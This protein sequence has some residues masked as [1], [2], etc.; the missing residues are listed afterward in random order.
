[1]YYPKSRIIEGLYTNGG[2]FKYKINN[3][4]Y[5]GYYHKFYNG[6][7]FSG[8]TQ[9]SLPKQEII[10]IIGN[11]NSDVDKLYILNTD[12]K[13]ALFLND[14]DPIVDISK[15][16]QSEIIKYLKL[17]GLPT[18]E[19][20]PRNVPQIYY[21]NPTDKD[22]EN[23][24]IKRYFAMKINER[25]VFVEI[26]KDI[27]KKLK[28]QDKKWMWERYQIFTLVWTIVGETKSQ[29]EETNRNIL[30][31][32]QR[33]IRRNGLIAYLRGN[34][35]KFFK[36]LSQLKLE[37]APPQSKKINKTPPNANPIPPSPSE[38]R[39]KKFFDKKRKLEVAEILALNQEIEMKEGQQK[40]N[41]PLF[42]NPDVKE[43][44][45]EIPEIPNETNGPIPPTNSSP[46]TTTGGY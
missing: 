14:P 6:K 11:L 5:I 15:W 21:P 1:M 17:K 33:E 38:V 29:V 35:S 40:P 43:N 27:Y 36:S 44:I 3:E 23:R 12:T 26:S 7:T 30:Y 46:S 18:N 20:N 10:P 37:M 13:I 41:K 42:G 4:I 31:L 32:K 24:T 39:S 45:S 22:Y 2:E 34:Y 19:D 25:D 28:D 8:K 9:N 16:N